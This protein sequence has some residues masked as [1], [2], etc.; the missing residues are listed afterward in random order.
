MDDDQ[1]KSN[2]D[3]IVAKA[4]KGDNDT[5]IISSLEDG[6]AKFQRGSLMM[7]SK[8]TVDDLTV[9]RKYIV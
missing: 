8:A 3:E 1:E 6:L 2:D 5:R 7:V 9:G 4:P